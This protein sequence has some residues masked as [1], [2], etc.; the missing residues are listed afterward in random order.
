MKKFFKFGCLG[1]VLMFIVILVFGAIHEFS[2]ADES[3]ATPR[4]KVAKS[5]NITLE[6]GEK[7][8]SVLQNVGIKENIDIQHDELLDNAHYESEKGYRINSKEASNIIL[9]MNANE[10]ISLIKYGDN[11][12]YENNSVVASLTDFILTE[13]EKAELKY[14]CQETIKGILKAPSTAKFPNYNEWRFGKKS[15]E[16]IIQSYVDAQN[17]FGANIRSKFQ[18]IIKDDKITSLIFDGKEYMKR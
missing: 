16:I 12:L 5:L 7:A 11:T 18:F 1:F 8:L 10:T 6:N 2:N 3:G 13:E 9:Y 14:K 15:G 4:G 17:G